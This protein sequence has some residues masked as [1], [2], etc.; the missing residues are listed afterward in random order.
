MASIAELELGLCPPP[1][2]CTFPKDT[3]HGLPS[4]R[5]L[6]LLFLLSSAL[7][8]QMEMKLRSLHLLSPLRP[9]HS[10][11]HTPLLYLYSVIPP[12]MLLITDE[13]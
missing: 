9:P 3:F 11:G 8:L 10:H 2:K 1:L 6:F 5:S 4:S 7:V 13:S 12:L